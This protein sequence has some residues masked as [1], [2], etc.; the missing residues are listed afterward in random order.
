MLD[1]ALANASDL[2]R[3]LEFMVATA[4]MS[5][6]VQG[7]GEGNLPISTSVSLGENQHAERLPLWLLRIEGRGPGASFQ[8]SCPAA[9]SLELLVV[10]F[11]SF[12][13]PVT[14]QHSDLF[15]IPGR[16][17]PDPS[18]IQAEGGAEKHDL[19]RNGVLKR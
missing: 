4:S 5:R 3:P 6:P 7:L 19:P 11:K 13:H 12:A 10:S 1:D 2:R 18:T 15:P 17:A 8:S 14:G 9:R 16:M